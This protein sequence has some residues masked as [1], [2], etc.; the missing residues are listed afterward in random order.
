MNLAS[1]HPEHYS[2]C[3]VLILCVSQPAHIPKVSSLLKVVTGSMVG[4]I[5]VIEV[6][7]FGRDAGDVCCRLFQAG[8]AVLWAF[9]W[10]ARRK[11]QLC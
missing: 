5:G 7:S 2:L 9:R 6:G 11:S 3:S 8:L 10:A 4:W 1:Y